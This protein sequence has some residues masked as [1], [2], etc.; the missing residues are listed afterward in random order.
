MPLYVLDTNVFIEA[1]RDTYPLDVATS[2][3]NTLKKL[4]E[5]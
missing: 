3:W 5:E 2:F 1:H 4:A